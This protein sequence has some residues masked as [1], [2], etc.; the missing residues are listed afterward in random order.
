MACRLGTTALLA[1]PAALAADLPT[2][3]DPRQLMFRADRV[4]NA[5]TTTPD[6]RIFVGFPQADRP[7]VQVEALDFHHYPVAIYR[8]PIG[9]GPWPA[10]HR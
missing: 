9:V 8:L 2:R 6:G 7:G 1:A 4:W 5:V 10:D 3:Q